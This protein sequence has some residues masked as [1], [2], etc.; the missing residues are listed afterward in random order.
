MGFNLNFHLTTF[1]KKEEG[2]LFRNIIDWTSDGQINQVE[3]VNHEA[4]F[5]HP[6]RREII[7]NSPA[8]GVL[9][10][11]YY[12]S[13]W[14]AF[15]VK[16]GKTIDLKIYQGGL[17]QQYIPLPA[18]IE[19]PYKVVMKYGKYPL[20]IVGIV[21]SGLIFIILIIYLIYPPSIGKI[22]HKFSSRLRLK[23]TSWW[24]KDEEE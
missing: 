7:V 12:F 10:K 24:D 1:R 5:I 19:Y 9:N 14:K 20:E 23:T 17:D 15:L 22:W 18:K 21:I 16:D 13:A 8:Q 3:A 6:E 11:E 4:R 2:Q